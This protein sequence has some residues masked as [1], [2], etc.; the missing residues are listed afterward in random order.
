MGPKK[1]HARRG[2]RLSR[3]DPHRFFTVMLV[4]SHRTFRWSLARNTILWTLGIA[5]GLWSLAMV[6]SAYGFWATKKIMSFSQLQ[7]E[8]A[9]QQKRLRDT[10]NKARGLEDEIDTLQRQL[11]ELQKLID[12]KTLAPELPPPP[13]AASPHKGKI[14]QL[15]GEI[16]RTWAQTKAIRAAMD[17]IIE[18]WNHTPSIFP[19]AG[20]MS[21]GYGIRL[22]PFSRANEQDDGL[23]GFHQGIDISNSRGTP[24]QATADGTIETAGWQEGYGNTLVIRHTPDIETL[25]GHLDTIAPQIKVG[26]LVARGD[27]LGYMGQSGRATGVHL[28]YEVRIDGRPKDP[29]PYMRL[30]REWLSSFK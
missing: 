4:F 24:I 26:Q 30:Q 1:L 29:K 18:R 22:S 7:A 20:Y 23:L 21:S 5:M 2:V 15:Q 13:E 6:G 19:T 14:S 3:P 11:T 28:H 25:Y 16:E 17:P 9:Q 27:I 12:P 10:L 8:T